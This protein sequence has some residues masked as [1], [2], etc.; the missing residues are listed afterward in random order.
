MSRESSLSLFQDRATEIQVRGDFDHLP[1]RLQ[2]AEQV[3][4]QLARHLEPLFKLFHLRWRKSTFLKQTLQASR[5]P[6][7]GLVEGDTMGRQPQSTVLTNGHTF[8]Y[9]L[10]GHRSKDLGRE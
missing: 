2:H 7:F 10:I 4:E 9:Q 3:S 6:L 8:G 5:G 1:A